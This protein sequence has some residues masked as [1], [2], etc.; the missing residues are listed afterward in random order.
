MAFIPV[1]N[2]M[3]AELV[4]SCN[5]QTVENVMNFNADEAYN[6]G[7]MSGQ[8]ALALKTWWDTNLK[9]GCPSAVSLLKIKVTD[10]T[11][12]TGS[13]LEYATGLPIAGTSAQVL[14]PNNV[15]IAVKLGTA[16]RGRSYRG[17]IFHVGLNNTQISGSQI[18]TSAATTLA[19][20]YANLG[21][22]VSTNHFHIG[23]VSRQHDKV[24]RTEGV[25]T[26]VTG[27]SI[28]LNLDSQRRRLPGRGR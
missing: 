1:P 23:V 12:Q 6:F 16:L 3:K 15:T 17:R 11:T 24:V 5:G 27:V 2:I 10:L 8:L 14:A 7:T 28:D 22:L 26:P 20:A 4:F 25:F 9:A 19:A 21:T 13:T 18:T